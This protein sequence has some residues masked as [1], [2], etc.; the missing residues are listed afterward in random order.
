MQTV[1]ERIVEP[2]WL[3]KTLFLSDNLPVMRRMNSGLLD[4]IYLDPPFNS[5]RKFRQPLGDGGMR[6]VFKDIWRE[7]D[8]DQAECA[9]LAGEY[10]ALY[11]AITAAKT[12][13][14]GSM[15]SYL[16]MMAPRLMECHRL[17]KE[18]GSLYLHCD[19]TASHY[20]K[21][22]LDA[23]F[24]P[25]NFRNEIVWCYGKWSNRSNCFQRN[26]DHILFYAK[27]EDATF[28]ILR[29]FSDDKKRKMEKGYIT[30]TV[31]NAKSSSGRIRQLIVYDRVKAAVK[32]KEGDYDNIVYAEGKGSPMKNWWTIPHLNSQAKERSGYPT[33]KPQAL[34]ERIIR[35]SSNQGDWVFDPFCG[36]ATTL[37]AAEKLN[38]KWI[39]I[40]VSP[41]SS[42]EI[43][44]RMIK[45]AI[46]RE[47][48]ELAIWKG[49]HNRDLR[50][51]KQLA[52]LDRTEWGELPPPRTHK[53]RLF[54]E[55]KG[56]CAAAGCP[57]N[58][59][60]DNMEVDHIVPKSKGGTDHGS[61]LQLL[62]SG[63]NRKK[64]DR[65]QAYLDDQL[66]KLG[67]TLH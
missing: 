65:P 31:R 43:K 53:K 54:G 33:Q 20:L 46:D 55:Q 66:K 63:C 25:Q 57:N 29:E 2:N 67:I 45:L 62:C 6:E 7:T 38:R 23:I 36:C 9:Q 60:Y 32:I 21:T 59:G 13:H 28:N 49:I 10:P 1:A 19:P 48:N 34:L 51:A 26:T 41:Q 18:T 42:K 44:K 47:E 17:L 24:Q 30:N 37:V 3:N 52:Q 35:A 16:L 8:L 4:L 40:D 39:G 56:Q 11:S 14:G 12:C 64:G 50:T 58:P 61:N 15:F 5:N 27:T 22:I